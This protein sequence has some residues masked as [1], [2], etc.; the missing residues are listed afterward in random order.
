MTKLQLHVLF[1]SQDIKQKFIIKF[2]F[3]QLL[4]SQTLRFIFEH[5]VRQSLTR[6]RKGKMGIQTFE[7]LENEKS[8]LD[9]IKTVFHNY[10]RVIIW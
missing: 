7:Y 8:F 10:F 1:P 9:E 3:R 5:P 6:Q 2:L 4:T